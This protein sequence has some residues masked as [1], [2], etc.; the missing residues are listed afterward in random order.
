MDRLRGKVALVTGGS[1][2]LG[3]AMVTRMA[4]EG[5]S[6]AIVDMLDQEGEQLSRALKARPK[7]SRVSPCS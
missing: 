7:E 2:G 4:E 6:V 5:A 3:H 1:L